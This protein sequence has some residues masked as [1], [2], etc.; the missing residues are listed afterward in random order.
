MGNLPIAVKKAGAQPLGV[1]NWVLLAD[2]Q[3]HRRGA[4]G[5]FWQRFIEARLHKIQPGDVQVD[6]A[7]E[8]IFDTEHFL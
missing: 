7:N 3:D 4:T 1:D 5:A 8:V 6:D 2:R